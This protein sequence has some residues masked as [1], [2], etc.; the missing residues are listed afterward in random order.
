MLSS[1]TTSTGPQL[2]REHIFFFCASYL[3]NKWEQVQGGWWRTWGAKRCGGLACAAAKTSIESK[4]NNTYCVSTT[5]LFLDM[6][7]CSRNNTYLCIDTKLSTVVGHC[8]KLRMAYYQEGENDE[9]MHI[10]AASCGY[11]RGCDAALKMTLSQGRVKCKNGKMIRTSLVW[12][13]AHPHGAIR[14]NISNTVNSFW[15]P[16]R[17]AEPCCIQIDA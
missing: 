3:A 2:H 5:I 10:F 6:F 12:I 9:I 8:N 15:C 1:S 4:E 13:Q 17:S 11:I 14:R 7:S 16:T